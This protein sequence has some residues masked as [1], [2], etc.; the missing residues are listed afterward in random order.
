MSNDLASHILT[1]DP[2]DV[3]RVVQSRTTKEVDY[4]ALRS[5]SRAKRPLSFCTHIMHLE[6]PAVGAHDGQM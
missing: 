2:H 6:E 5:V 1:T 4:F 3:W